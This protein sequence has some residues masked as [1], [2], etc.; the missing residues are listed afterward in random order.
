MENEDKNMGL[1]E[2]ENMNISNI[3]KPDYNDQNLDNNRNYQ[4]WKSAMIDKYGNNGKFYKCPNDKI[5]FYTSNEENRKNHENE[6]KCPLCKKEICF[7]CMKNASSGY[8]HCCLK[9]KY[10]VM[11]AE[12]KSNLNEKM[13]DLGD[14]EQAFIKFFL[15]PGVNIIFFIAMFFNM[16]Y[17]K[18][19][20]GY[21]NGY[22]H[23]YESFFPNHCSRYSLILINGITSIFL[24]IAFFIYGILFAIIFLSIIIFK[25]SLCMFLIGFFHEDWVYIY[26]NFHKVFHING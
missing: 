6:G 25:K 5:F 3:F 11:C 12:G 24:G 7:F 2:I 15:I 21:E 1:I 14:Y 9:K 22:N 4:N 16:T 18:L 10:F 17:Y 23:P 19:A 20:M 13:S 8:C 26:K